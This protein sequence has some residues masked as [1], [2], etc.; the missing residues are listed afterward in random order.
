MRNSL[1][2]CIIVCDVLRVAA[3]ELPRQNYNVEQAEPNNQI[4]L[5]DNAGII[6]NTI[7]T[8]PAIS[9]VTAEPTTTPLAVPVGKTLSATQLQLSSTQKHLIDTRT[10][11]S[12]LDDT[13]TSR[14]SSVGSGITTL[15][16]P[17]LL[18]T[19][20]TEVSS[21]TSL[22]TSADPTRTLAPGTKPLILPNITLVNASGISTGAIGPTSAV[23]QSSANQTSIQSKAGIVQGMP[24]TTVYILAGLSALVVSTVIVCLI[25]RRSRRYKEAL[26]EEDIFCRGEGYGYQKTLSGSLQKHEAVYGGLTQNDNDPGINSRLKITRRISPVHS[27]EYNSSEQDARFG[28]SYGDD[29]RFESPRSLSSAILDPLRMKGRKTK[30]S[31]SL[32][33]KRNEL[34][35]TDNHESSIYSTDVALPFRLGSPIRR[36]LSVPLRHAREGSYRSASWRAR[37]LDKIVS[38]YRESL[39][40][41]FES[42]NRFARK[43]QTAI[44]SHTDDLKFV[45]SP[46]LH[47]SEA[48]RKHALVEGTAGH[49]YAT[50]ATD[51]VA[52]PPI[53]KIP[54]I[55][56]V[57]RNSMQQ[58]FEAMGTIQL[59]GAPEE[60]GN[61]TGD[62]RRTQVYKILKRL[63]GDRRSP[64]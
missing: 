18:P 16:T 32:V 27:S 6:D 43:S 10:T 34:F 44:I 11:P 62:G 5:L 55:N 46:E 54:G 56:Q 59:G 57:S 63:L 61:E 48:S 42:S 20:I 50:R 19:R 40:P 41:K 3:G 29:K 22:R 51:L 38:S 60:L 58:R 36:T 30:S 12:P 47:D 17:Y 53:L 15:F 24:R 7:L 28:Q 45:E 64:Q 14:Q 52:P 35:N 49:G 4:E 33:K 2:L 21:K 25:K 1:V 31:E 39:R 8:I 9:F 13:I 23:N 37:G 26:R